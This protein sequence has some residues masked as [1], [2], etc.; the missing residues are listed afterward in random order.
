LNKGGGEILELIRPL[1]D[2]GHEAATHG[3]AGTEATETPA[4]VSSQI[5]NGAAAIKEFS[6]EQVRT[7]GLHIPAPSPLLPFEDGQWRASEQYRVLRTKIGQHPK[8]PR[9][10]VISSPAPGDGK[11]VS[12]INLAA[13]LSLRSEGRVLLVDADFRKSAIHVQLGLPATPGL[14]DVLRGTCSAEEALVN[15]R[16][17]S[18]LY[19]MCAGTPPANPV[20]LLDSS[21]WPALCVK[22]R[23]LFRY[24]VIDSPPVAAVADFDL[25]QAPCDGVVL[26]VRPDHTNR[27]LLRKSLEIVAKPKFLGGVAEL[28]AG[29]VFGE[30]LEC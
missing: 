4:P 13:T 29:V 23:S 2:G 9:L 27:P 20:E 19:V 25:I 18:N 30:G 11:S 17:L 22:L 12:A 16:E 7:V 3:S 6:L 8:Q 10:I 26:V 15:T 28:C 14:A 24:V 21:P 1:V 5:P